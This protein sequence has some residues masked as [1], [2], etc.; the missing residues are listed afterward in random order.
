MTAPRPTPRRTRLLLLVALAAIALISA[1]IMITTVSALRG[2]RHPAAGSPA[3]SSAP[4]PPPCSQTW[5]TAPSG[6]VVPVL[7]CGGP[8]DTRGGRARGFTHTAPGA[9]SAAINITDRLS[10]LSGV[11]VYVPTY[12]EQTVGD[13]ATAIAQL[14]AAGTAT[15]AAETRPNQWW[16]RITSG[17]PAGDEVV[18]DVAASTPESRS[19]GTVAHLAVRLRWVDQP[20]GGDWKVLLPRT[21][22]TPLSNLD[23]YT[24]L[25]VA[26][27]NPGGS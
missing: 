14:Q 19:A 18:V 21:G 25:G 23:G 17:N 13:S 27:D 22:A 15:P 9:V 26:P 4:A 20:G 8:R 7:S 2:G 3:Q 12:L 11:E 16:W 24:D 5:M 1:L 6:D 10:G